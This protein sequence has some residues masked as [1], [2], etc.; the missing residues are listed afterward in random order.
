MSKTFKTQRRVE[1]CET[2]AAGIVHFSALLCYIEQVEHAMLRSLGVSVVHDLGDGW[3]L[4]WPRVR[5][6]CDFQGVA[7]FEDVL[8][9]ELSVIRL[10][11]KSVTY[12]V[13]LT[14]TGK[15]V[16]T[17]KVIAVCC[18]VRA[19]EPL[20]SMPIPTELAEKLSLYQCD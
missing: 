17:S 15:P 7:K 13:V 16:A 5:V 1:F 12:Q 18:R 4:S 6:E 3:H 2:D 20:D 10:G 19:G 11:G 14:N 9:A 8:D